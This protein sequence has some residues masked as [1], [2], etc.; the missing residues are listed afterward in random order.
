MRTSGFKYKQNVVKTWN[1]LQ[2]VCF[3]FILW[4]NIG[5]LLIDIKCYLLAC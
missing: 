3:Y 5:I 1:P 2:I 4:A